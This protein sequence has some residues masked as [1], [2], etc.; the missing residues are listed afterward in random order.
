M[1]IIR[2]VR[3]GLNFHPNVYFDVSFS[4]DVIISEYFQVSTRGKETINWT[5]EMLVSFFK[6]TAKHNSIVSDSPKNKNYNSLAMQNEIIETFIY[7][8]SV[9]NLKQCH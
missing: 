5:Q 9:E 4:I 2:G 1:G 8:M 3:H 6:F 7:M